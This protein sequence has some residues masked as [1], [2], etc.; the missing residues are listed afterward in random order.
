MLTIQLLS[1]NTYSI[2][3]IKDLLN[4]GVDG[5]VKIGDKVIKKY[6][7]TGDEAITLLATSDYGYRFRI[8]GVGEDSVVNGNILSN[9]FK[10][11]SEHRTNSK[12]NVTTI[13]EDLIHLRDA[14]N[15]IGIW[16]RKEHG[17]TTVEELKTYFKEN[18][19]YVM[20]PVATPQTINLPSIKP[21]ELFEGTNIFELVTNLGTTLA[22]TYKV[23][24]KKKILNLEERIS[25]LESAVIGG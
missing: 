16:V 23:S 13:D 17:I 3:Q 10:F 21:I 9:A 15:G 2:E 11:K 12:F 18:D 7:F 8:L 5:S 24:N 1:S 19:I 14:N 25:A 4:I 22:V 6:V 20:Y